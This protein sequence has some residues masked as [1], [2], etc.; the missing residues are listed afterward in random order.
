MFSEHFNDTAN[1]NITICAE[2]IAGRGNR[3]ETCD[4]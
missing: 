3:A 4:P 2:E 1:V